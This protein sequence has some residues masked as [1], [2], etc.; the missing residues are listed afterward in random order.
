MLT[1]NEVSSHIAANI[2][3]LLKARTMSQSE[4]ARQTGETQ[5]T[6]SRLANGNQLP[7]VAILS[8]IADVFD[9][10]IDRMI[11]E[12]EKNISDSD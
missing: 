2:R 3:R 7:N 12:P 4:L 10:T 9:V 11:A 5:A 6:I 8:R 1:D